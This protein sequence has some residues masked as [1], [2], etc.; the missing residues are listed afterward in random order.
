M[1]S[2][3]GCMLP[4]PVP[5]SMWLHVLLVPWSLLCDYYCTLNLFIF[6][7]LIP[8][9]SGTYECPC[10]CFSHC[11]SLLL[12]ISMTESEYLYPPSICQ[13]M[14]GAS[15]SP[16]PGLLRGQCSVSPLEGNTK[17]A[18]SSASSRQRFSNEIRDSKHAI[19]QEH[20]QVS[21]DFWDRKIAEERELMMLLEK[22]MFRCSC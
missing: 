2:P 19:P 8:C 20:K 9:V 13:V 5:C 11:V 18:F 15:G 1:P 4:L 14:A 12:P 21:V 3:G 7:R 16:L 10:Y 6:L 22:V 17:L